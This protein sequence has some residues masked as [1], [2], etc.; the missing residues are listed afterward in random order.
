MQSIPAIVAK[1]LDYEGHGITL[2]NPQMN[3]DF[4]QG[5]MAED[6]Y[7]RQVPAPATMA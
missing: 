3:L 6:V 5:A 7:K 2:L 1:E 4:G